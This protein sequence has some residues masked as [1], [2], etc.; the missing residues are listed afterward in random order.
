MFVYAWLLCAG[1]ELKS[2]TVIELTQVPGL[3]SVHFS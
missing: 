1:R 3:K 2:N